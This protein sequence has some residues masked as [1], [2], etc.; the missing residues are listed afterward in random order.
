MINDLVVKNARLW[1]YVDDTTISETVA[2][3][4][5]SNAQRHTDKVIQ[6]SLEN[7]VQSNNEKCQEMR[8][9]FSKFQQEFEPILINDDVLEVVENVKL[10]G[11][12]ISS[13]L[14]WNIHINKIVFYFPTLASHAHCY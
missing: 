1:K 11:L 5:L 3:G 2:K 12:N 6:W 7:R 8:I 4:E 13:N 14:T 10:L 9:S